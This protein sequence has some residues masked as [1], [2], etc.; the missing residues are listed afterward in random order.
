MDWKQ[1]VSTVAPGLATALGGPMAGVA[2][3]GIASALLGDEDVPSTDVETAVL[4]ASP[5]D[6]RKLKQAELVFRQQMKELEIDLE[7]LH[8]AD[9]E[10]ARERQVVTGDQM[11]AFIAFAAL[12]GFFG[13]LISMIFV[14]LPAGSEAPLNVM[15]GALGSLVVAI[16]NYY[17][18]SSAGSSAKNQLIEQLIGSQHFVSSKI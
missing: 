10:S 12:A 13:I 17:F 8:A 1:I 9:R 16:G 7:A 4:R 5:S 11:P 2:V 14:D 3:R 6:L 18:G 15:L